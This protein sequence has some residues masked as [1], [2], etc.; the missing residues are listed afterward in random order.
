MIKLNEL[1]KKSKT[2]GLTL[3]EFKESII[4]LKRIAGAKQEIEV[5]NQL[6]YNKLSLLDFHYA[7]EKIYQKAIIQTKLDEYV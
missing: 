2:V 6:S 7:Y 5:L 1:Y 4:I 3:D